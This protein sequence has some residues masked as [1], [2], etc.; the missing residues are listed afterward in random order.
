MSDPSLL[1]PIPRP[2]RA[3][4]GGET[5]SNAKMRSSFD[6]TPT[7]DNTLDVPLRSTLLLELRDDDTA[8]V[9]TYYSTIS[10][11]YTMSNLP[12]PGRLLGNFYSRAGRTLEKHLGRVVHRAA[13]KEYEQAVDVL[14]SDGTHRMLLGDEPKEHERACDVLLICAR[15]DDV[16]IQ[17][18][19]FE[20][21]VRY[22]VYFPSK[23]RSAFRRVFERRSEISDV[24][25]FSWKRSGVE[26]SVKWLLWY[27]LASRCLSS[28][29]SSFMEAGAKFDDVKRKSLDF[30][31]FESL[32]LSCG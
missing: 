27:K 14:K 4:T 5:G 17:V 15:S 25:T 8:T 22:F 28:H 26:Y 30:L 11:N 32:L 10:T 23:I 20:K 24:A 2:L 12:G 29:H 3:M 21:I 31:N 6:E 19:A 7:L 9:Y 18:G 16:N 13:I 1:S